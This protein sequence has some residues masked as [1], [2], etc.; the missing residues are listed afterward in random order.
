[1]KYTKTVLALAGVMLVLAG[2]SSKKESEEEVQAIIEMMSQ[3]GLTI[4]GF[5]N[6]LQRHA[7]PMV[8]D[9]PAAKTEATPVT[10][11]SDQQAFGNTPVPGYDGT[12]TWLGNLKLTV[13][14]DGGVAGDWMITTTFNHTTVSSGFEVTGSWTETGTV[15]GSTLTEVIL[16]ENINSGFDF[17]VNG[18]SHSVN[19]TISISVTPNGVTSGTCWGIID[20]TAVSFPLVLN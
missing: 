1:M 2:C 13:C 4:A 3:T 20:S 12:A 16:N 10:C 19:L 9:N 15:T 11:I 5:T 6:E 8:V 7:D 18:H 14:T 17:S